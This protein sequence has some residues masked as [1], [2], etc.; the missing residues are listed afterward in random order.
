MGKMQ[1][2]DHGTRLACSELVSP[3][4]PGEVRDDWN[5]YFFELIPKKIL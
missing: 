2:L 1:S 3:Q 4:D 5:L